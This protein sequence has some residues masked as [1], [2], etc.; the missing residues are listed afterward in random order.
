MST[1]ASPSFT[2]S[3]NP[4]LACESL[5]ARSNT[6]ANSPRSPS[7]SC[8]RIEEQAVFCHEQPRL[9]RGFG[10]EV[11]A[12]RQEP[13]GGALKRGTGAVFAWG[14]RLQAP[15][16]RASSM[17][18]RPAATHDWRERRQRRQLA[19]PAAL[20]EDGVASDT[21]DRRVEKKTPRGCRCRPFRS[22]PRIRELP[23]CRSPGPG[24]GAL[25][26]DLTGLVG[27]AALTLLVDENSKSLF[28]SSRRAGRS[29]R[30]LCREYPQR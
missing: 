9:R 17:L 22:S 21:R 3:D 28:S 18:L 27:H 2:G 23:A 8:R 14:A 19:R 4:G 11:L 24:Y 26:P 10:V 15:P 29:S 1:T 7:D 5:F 6:S 12:L 30:R 13:P 16:A 20:P 25:L